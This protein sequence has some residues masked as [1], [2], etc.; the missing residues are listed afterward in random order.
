MPDSSVDITPW[1]DLSEAERD[2]TGEALYLAQFEQPEPEPEPE[3]E[4]VPVEPKPDISIEYRFTPR[5]VRF[6][7]WLHNRLGRGTRDGHFDRMGAPLSVLRVFVLWALRIVPRAAECLAVLL[8]GRADFECVK[9]R[10]LA[11]DGCA[12][13]KTA[14]NGR[15]YCGGCTCPAWIGSRLAVKN[16]RKR[17]HCPKRTHAGSYVV[18]DAFKWPARDEKPG[19]S[20]GEVKKGGCGAR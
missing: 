14:R 17:N 16:G 18:W 15:L 19:P 1:R 8:S 13:R 3:P 20:V 12:A 5:S 9:A 11:C 4:P 7:Q 2:A 10:K 6:C